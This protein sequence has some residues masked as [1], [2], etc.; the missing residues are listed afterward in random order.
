MT[1]FQPLQSCGLLPRVACQYEWLF[2]RVN[3]RYAIPMT[4]KE[5]LRVPLPEATAASP[6]YTEEHEAF[7]AT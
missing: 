3:E 7:R 4:E 6:F 2:S 1:S 5:S